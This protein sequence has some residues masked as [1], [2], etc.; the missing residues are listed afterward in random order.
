MCLGKE[1]KKKIQN[2]NVS[3]FRYKFELSNLVIPYLCA[4]YSIQCIFPI[5]RHQIE[6][7]DENKTK[8]LS[9]C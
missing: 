8:P 7:S 9:P 6:I 5:S 2:K 1:S 3:V 4:F